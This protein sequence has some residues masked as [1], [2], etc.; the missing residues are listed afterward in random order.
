MAPGRGALSGQA[1]DRLA[2][3]TD[4]VGNRVSGSANLRRAVTY[5]LDALSTEP[6]LENV[7]GEPV[8]VPHWVRGREGGVMLAPR[9]GYKLNLLGLGSS[10]GTLGPAGQG[11]APL[12]AEVVVVADWAELETRG[13]AGEVEGKVCWCWMCCGVDSCTACRP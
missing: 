6:G 2:Q 9:H 4:T 5:M 13:R 8:M 1:W 12:V 7:A 11:F 10:V 3:L